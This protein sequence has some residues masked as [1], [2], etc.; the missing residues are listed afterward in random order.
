MLTSLKE[1]EPEDYEVLFPHTARHPTSKAIKRRAHKCPS[2]RN[3]LPESSNS[4]SVKLA[5]IVPGE[6]R[7]FDAL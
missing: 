2:N 6:V 4:S 3:I 1:K 7:K 5:P